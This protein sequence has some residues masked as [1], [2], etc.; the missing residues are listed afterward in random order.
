MSGDSGNASLRRGIKNVPAI[1]QE[2]V[3]EAELGLKPGFFPLEKL[4]ANRPPSF[5]TS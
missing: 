5:R 3:G 4:L 1:V 2:E